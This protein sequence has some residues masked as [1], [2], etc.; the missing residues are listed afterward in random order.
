MSWGSNAS[1]KEH[2]RQ[3]CKSW[4][5]EIKMYNFNRQGF[6]MQT[7]HFTAMVWKGTTQLGIGVAEVNGCVCV[8]ANYKAKPNMQGDF[9]NNVFPWREVKDDLD[10]E[11]LDSKLCTFKSTQKNFVEQNY[12]RCNTCGMTEKEGEGV[13]EICAKVCHKGHD[14]S[15][16]IFGDFFCDC[17][18][19]A[20]KCQALTKRSE[21]KPI[22]QENTTTLKGEVVKT[23][24]EKVKNEVPVKNDAEVK[25]EVEK[26]SEG[27]LPKEV[28]EAFE[29]LQDEDK[30]IGWSELKDILDKHIK[31][32]FKFDGFD[33]AICSLLISVMTIRNGEKVRIDMENL[34]NIG[35]SVDGFLNA[36][37]QFDKDKSGTLDPFELKSALEES[38]FKISYKTF[39]IL[40]SQLANDE[41]HVNF[42]GFVLCF[43][44][45]SKLQV[46]METKSQAGMFEDF[47]MKDWI[48]EEMNKVAS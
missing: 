14:L 3:A 25:K 22:D 35:S 29:M 19:D 31:I 37:Q 42:R 43:L 34:D 9:S 38:G 33:K 18:A 11:P 46:E 16:S 24:S 20:T 8:V 13:C 21:Q 7:G 10:D 28:K 48:S 6:S 5:D 32:G 41:G 40:Q 17:G 4:Y 12:Y 15:S 30:T 27:V 47:S 23:E 2:V 39:Q 44:L 36:Y 1:K 26:S 45:L